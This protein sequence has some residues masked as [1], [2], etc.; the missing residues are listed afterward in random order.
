MFVN[1]RLTY[2]RSL[3]KQLLEAIALNI[4]KA[5]KTQ[6]PLPEQIEPKSTPVAG[7]GKK[8]KPRG[9]HLPKPPEP[10]PPIQERLSPMSPLAE[11]GVLVET[12]KVAL[13]QQAT[14]EKGDGPGGSSGGKGKRKIVRVRA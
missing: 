2:I 6:I 12:V 4:Q 9:K 10:F 14:A 7:D 13:G 3:E 8:H 11:A 1:D 5:D